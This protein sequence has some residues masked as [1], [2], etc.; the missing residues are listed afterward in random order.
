MPSD[1]FDLGTGGVLELS[2]ELMRQFK[3]PKGLAEKFRVAF[4]SAS[5]PNQ[6]AI[7]VEVAKILG[8][9]AELRGASDVNKLSTAEL[10]AAALRLLE[11]HGYTTPWPEPKESTNGH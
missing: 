4:D 9:A 11:D 5:E 7:L 8:N 1:T 10:R 6:R 3:G 2:A